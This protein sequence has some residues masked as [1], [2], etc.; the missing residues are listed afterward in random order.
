MKSVILQDVFSNLLLSVLMLAIL[1][2]VLVGL[3]DESPPQVERCRLPQTGTGDFVVAFAQ[4]LNNPALGEILWSRAPGDALSAAESDLTQRRFVA[5]MRQGCAETC[6]IC[7]PSD[8]PQVMQNGAGLSIAGCT[9]QP[10][11]Q[12]G[13]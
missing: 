5:L 4:P 13:A 9:P 2:L 8:Q 6:R 1:A 3:P 7:A 11:R 12:P 10:C